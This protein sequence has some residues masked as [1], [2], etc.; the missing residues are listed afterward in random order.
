MLGKPSLHGWQDDLP[1]KLVIY[2]QTIEM[3]TPTTSATW[4]PPKYSTLKG[5]SE[6]RP[7]PEEAWGAVQEDLLVGW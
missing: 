7:I 3:P 4:V 2:K 6:A 1:L 5:T